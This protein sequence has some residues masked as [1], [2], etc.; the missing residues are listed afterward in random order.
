MRGMNDLILDRGKPEAIPSTLGTESEIDAFMARPYPEVVD[1]MRRLKGDIAILGV[2]GKMGVALGATAVIASRAAGVSRRV[3]GVSRFSNAAAFDAVARTGMTPLR[4][5]LLDSQAVAALPRAP[6]VIFMAGRKFGTTGEEEQTWAT[7]TLTPARVCEHFTDSRIVAF[8]T[9][10]VYPFVPVDSGGCTEETPP[11]PVGE[12]AQSCLGRERIFAYYALRNKTPVC[13]LR[14][15]YALDL[16]YGVIHDLALTIWQGRPVSR[17]VPFFNALWQGDAN[18][19]T[20][21]TLDAATAP[22]T[23]LNLTGP[24][25]LSVTE[26]AETLGR[27]LGKPVVFDGEPGPTAYLNNSARLHARFGRPCVPVARVIEWTAAW[28]RAG[29]L[30]Y[31]KPTHF[32][33]ANGTF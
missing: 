3:Y 26:I 10:C 16:R 17:R 1:L 6:N 14:L 31:G 15:N 28:V 9:G 27:L 23:V 12:Y 24:E 29:G 11:G 22:A 5:D 30:S 19:L 18:N 8:S 20:L 13:L 32:E 7:N 4:C 21:L 2:A 33:V 25:V